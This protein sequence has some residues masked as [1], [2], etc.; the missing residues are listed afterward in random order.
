MLPLSRNIFFVDTETT[1]ANPFLNDPLSVALVPL[2][3]ELPS[4]L[5]HIR[6]PQLRWSEY[7]AKNFAKFEAEWHATAVPPSE[8]VAQIEAYLRQILRGDQA[9]LIGH[10]V[11][12]DLSFIRKLAA[13][14]GKEQVEGIS[15]RTIDTH[16][17]LYLAWLM[18]KVPMHALS[19]DGALSF[20]NVGMPDSIRHT[21]LGDAQAAKAIF[22]KILR[23]LRND[24]AH[25]NSQDSWLSGR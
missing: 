5:V 9:T 12:F 11:G 15:H 10:N 19:S 13:L 21:A 23:L 20:F 18:E 14:A 2:V 8:A 1:G 6:P 4:F 7:G 16:T 25:S 3:D 22:S 24:A 17:L